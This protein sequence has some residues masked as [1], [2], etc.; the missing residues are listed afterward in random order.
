MLAL[1]YVYHFHAIPTNYFTCASGWD[2]TNRVW[3]AAAPDGRHSPL[4]GWALDGFPIYGPY[5]TG[6]IMPVVGGPAATDTDACYGHTENGSWHYHARD[7]H[8]GHTHAFLGCFAGKTAA[9]AGSS[10]TA[11][12]A[13]GG[14]GGGGGGGGGAA[15]PPPVAPCAVAY[16][17]KPAS[18]Q[19]CCGDGWCDGPVET[20]SNCGAD[21]AAAATPGRRSLAA[22]APPTSSTAALPT[23]PTYTCPATTTVAAHTTPLGPAL[24][25]YNAA[26]CAASTAAAYT[27]QYST[28]CA[29]AAATTSASSTKAGCTV[30]AAAAAAAALALQA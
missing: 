14:M 11:G 13:M 6:G 10:V 8:D 1:R 20:T 29:A 19:H 25:T 24:G 15:S 7:V 16:G 30:L 4:I 26:T 28:P 21:C 18:T 27:G 23:C 5:T 22:V 2:G 9:Q 17:S 12:A 3:A